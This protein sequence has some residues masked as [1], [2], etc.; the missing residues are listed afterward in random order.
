MP[1]EERI[2][3]WREARSPRMKQHFF[4]P[5]IPPSVRLAFEP[6]SYQNGI[7]LLEIF[8]NDDNPF[9]DERF[10]TVPE[11]EDYLASMLEYAAFSSKRGAFD[12]LV[13]CDITGEYIGVCHLHDLSNQ[14]FGSENRKATI[15]Y[16]IGEKHRGKGFASEMVAHFSDFVFQNSIIIK[17]LVYTDKANFDSIRLMENLNW[18]RCDDKYVYS[19]TYAYFELW[20]EGYE[21][22]AKQ[23]NE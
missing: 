14:V 12:W 10:K 22:F 9:V 17:L 5:I 4:L 1:I 19:D 18:L 7:H 3:I 20:K 15:G 23:E 8:K 11:L 6:L 16:A 21:N 13:K 2:K